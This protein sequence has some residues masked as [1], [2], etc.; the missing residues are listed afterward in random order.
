MSESFELI[1]SLDHYQ[2]INYREVHLVA[3]FFF[4]V[5]TSLQN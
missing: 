5:L 1:G 4:E 3:D 2:I